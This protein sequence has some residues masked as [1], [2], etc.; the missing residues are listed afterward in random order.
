MLLLSA[1]S[2]S[3]LRLSVDTVCLLTLAVLIA[4]GPIGRDS[5]R[6]SAATDATDDPDYE[7]SRLLG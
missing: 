4:I 3:S 6:T 7:A 2:I 5:R 1:G